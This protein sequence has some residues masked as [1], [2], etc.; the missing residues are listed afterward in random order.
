MKLKRSSIIL[1]VIMW[2]VVFLTW[3]VLVLLSKIVPSFEVINISFFNLT[4]TSMNNL[5]LM[6]FIILVA[7]A[8]FI[9]GLIFT[10]ALTKNTQKYRTLL[11]IVGIAVS[12]ITAFLLYIIAMF[13]GFFFISGLFD[14]SPVY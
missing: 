2:S 8:T 6:L 10:L 14:N 9:S 3:P 11:I 12:I 5:G 13:I 7:V 4:F 1:L